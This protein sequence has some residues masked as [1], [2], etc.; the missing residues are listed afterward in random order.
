[1]PL[2]HG[3]RRDAGDVE[4]YALGESSAAGVMKNLQ[5]VNDEITVLAETDGGTPFAPALSALPP[6]SRTLPIIPNM[7]VL[8]FMLEIKINNDITV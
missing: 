2:N 1:M 6:K 7:T 3:F 4:T 8:R 5:A